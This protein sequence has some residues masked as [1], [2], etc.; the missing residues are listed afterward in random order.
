[1]YPRIHTEAIQ[2]DILITVRENVVQIISTVDP[3]NWK[4]PAISCGKCG[5]IFRA[6]LDEFE[7][8][9]SYPS[10]YDYYRVGSGPA[11]IPYKFDFLRIK[12]PKCDQ[13]HRIEDIPEPVVVMWLNKE[14]AAKQKYY[15]AHPETHHWFRD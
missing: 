2:S 8:S 9:F 1:M 11:W 7:K 12:C 10:Y 15:D 6:N 13:Y 5:T 14:K 4:P 3:D